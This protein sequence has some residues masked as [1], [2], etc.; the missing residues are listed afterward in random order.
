M[1]RAVGNTDESC[2]CISNIR[3]DGL[4]P[5]LAANKIMQLIHAAFLLQLTVILLKNNIVSKIITF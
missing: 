2:N 5:A 3:A 1:D 4:T